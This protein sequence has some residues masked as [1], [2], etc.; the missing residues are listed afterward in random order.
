[1]GVLVAI[2]A[3]FLVLEHADA[4]GIQVPA[5]GMESCFF[6]EIY[7]SSH[8]SVHFVARETVTVN[9]K[10][11]SG[12]MLYTKRSAVQG[13]YTFDAREDGPYHIC[14]A[15]D[16]MRRVPTTTKFR[17]LVLNQEIKSS[18]LPSSVQ[19]FDVRNLCLDVFN[20][21]EKALYATHL[22]S[23]TA[24]TTDETMLSSAALAGRLAALQCVAV[25]VT[26]LSQITHIRKILSLSRS[27]LQRMV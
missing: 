3:A 25:L 26:A 11:P 12:N 7:A 18:D 17:F 23:D 1:M 21:S 20:L 8:V 10:N 22:Y 27:K 19:T 14:I 9:I 6:R 24:T 2:L 13:E 16:I 4:F 15:T 5:G